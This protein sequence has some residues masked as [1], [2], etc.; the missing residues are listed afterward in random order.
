MLTNDLKSE[1]KR[2][3]ALTYDQFE[4]LLTKLPSLPNSFANASRAAATLYMYLMKMRTGQP[5]DDI[6]NKFGITRVTVERQITKV[7]AAMMTDFVHN[8]VNYIRNREDMIQAS[9]TMSRGLFSPDG[10]P[11]VMLN[12]DGTYIFI[13]KS[14]NYQFQKATYN[15][16][17][18]RNFVKIMMVVT[19]D[20]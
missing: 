18:K 2:N 19:C 4:D 9:T 7:R 11:R 16:Q 13:N 3:T 14:R 15:D 20:L 6:G 5:S 10:I 17:M 12:C 8:H 1:I